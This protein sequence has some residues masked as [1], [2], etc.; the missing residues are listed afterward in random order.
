MVLNQSRK[1]NLHRNDL[2]KVKREVLLIRLV[3]YLVVTLFVE[4]ND[5]MSKNDS[6]KNLI[7]PLSFSRMKVLNLLEE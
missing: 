4:E 7:I 5:V 2:I 3:S 6:S 1:L